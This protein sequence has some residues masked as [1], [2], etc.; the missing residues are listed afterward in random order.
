VNKKALIVLKFLLKSRQNF[1][2][3]HFLSQSFG[4][5]KWLNYIC[6]MLTDYSERA[7]MSG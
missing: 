7:S 2:S 4:D 6:S 5:T 1:F 3:S